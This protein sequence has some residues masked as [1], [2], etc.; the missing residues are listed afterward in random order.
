MPEQQDRRETIR[1][2]YKWLGSA[3]SDESVSSL[4]RGFINAMSQFDLAAAMLLSKDWAHKVDERALELHLFHIHSSRLKMVRHLLPSA[5]V[6]LDLGG[7][8]APLYQMGY[9]H[10]FERLVLI[11][12]PTEERHVEFQEVEIESQSEGR[13]V[14]RYEDMTDLKGIADSSVNLVWSGQSIEHVTP[15]QGRRMCAEAYRVLGPGGHFCLDTPNRLLTK[16]HTRD[17]GGG[18]IHPDHKVEY[19]PDELRAMLLEAG[20]SIEEEWGIC[21]MPLTMRDGKFNYLDFSTGGAITANIDDAYIQFF[22]CR[23]PN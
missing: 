6:I 13:V 22:K 16:V 2:I 12:L 18:F 14:V 10:A 8:N 4:E 3:A 7:A 21:E 1:I 23:K 5:R 19:T 9:P 11:D 20:F 17:V 15:D